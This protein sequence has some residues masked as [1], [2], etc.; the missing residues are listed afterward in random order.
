MLLA[1]EQLLYPAVQFSDQRLDKPWCAAASLLRGHAPLHRL[2]DVQSRHQM[3]GLMQRVL[4]STLGQTALP[5]GHGRRVAGH[6]YSF[7]RSAT[8]KLT[9]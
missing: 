8:G 3:E 9:F 6:G 7:G 4:K 5:S 1:L 2:M